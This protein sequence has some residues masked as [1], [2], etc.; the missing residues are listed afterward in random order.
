MKFKE[1]QK[2]IWNDKEHGRT[3]Y[4]KYREPYGDFNSLIY[5]YTK[6]WKSFG[7]ALVSNSELEEF[8][9]ESK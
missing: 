4:A 5:L 2:L 7:N 3:L 1:N 9:E 8:K 6:D